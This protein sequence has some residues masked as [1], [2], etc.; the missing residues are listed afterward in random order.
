MDHANLLPFSSLFREQLTSNLKLQLGNEGLTI[1]LP[2][3]ARR[4]KITSIDRWL[5]SFAIHSFLV[6]AS[7]PSRGV[8]LFAHQQLI[9]ES[10]K[11]FPGMTWYVYDVEFRRRASHDLSKKWGERNVQLYLD[12]FTGLP[13]SIL[14]I[15]LVAVQTMLPTHT[16]T[17]LGPRPPGDQPTPMT[18]ASTL[19][20]GNT[21]P[22]Q[23]PVQLTWMLSSP[24]RKGP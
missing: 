14:C 13:K 3:P 21:L 7:Y 2:S 23:T 18:S 24:L 17:L 5:H 20:K 10:G 11:K 15:S 19:T 12:T 22:L 1:P 6:L 8:E 9:R 4:P 16:P